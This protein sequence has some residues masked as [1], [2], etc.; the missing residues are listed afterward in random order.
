MHE[1]KVWCIVPAAGVG[2]RLGASVPKQYLQI[3]GIPILEMTLHKLLESRVFQKI[4]VALSPQDNFFKSL[5][6]AHHPDIIAVTGGKE[7]SDS[8][9]AGLS[10]LRL[11]ASDDDWVMV[12]D[13]ARPLVQSAQI[14]ELLEVCNKSQV[15]GILAVPVAD[16]L[17][18][19][20][21]SGQIDATVSRAHMWQ[22]QTPQCF[23]FAQL[24]HALSHCVQEGIE[25]TDEASAVE[26]V[27]EKCQLVV[28]R[29]DNIKI[30]RPDDLPFAEFI[31]HQQIVKNF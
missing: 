11:L 27:G 19:A 5:S 18:R 26:A 16:T 12:H 31:A 17:K 3:G 9:Y 7:R 22:A 23:P 21:E 20:N 25:I 28:G 6:L 13:A 1:R 8:V 4:V 29:A 10:H 24:K 14:H 15:G 30:T 2:S